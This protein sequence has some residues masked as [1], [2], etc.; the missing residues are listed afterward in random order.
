LLATLLKWRIDPALYV[1]EYG[2]AALRELPGD[3]IV[4]VLSLVVLVAC[5]LVVRGHRLWA[6]VPLVLD[7]AGLAFFFYLAYFFRIQF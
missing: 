1:R 2:T 6:V 7:A 3:G 4:L 5:G